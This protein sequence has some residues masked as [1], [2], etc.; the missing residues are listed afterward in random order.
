MNVD[1]ILIL[2]KK[3][4]LRKTETVWIVSLDN[5]EHPI[6]VY[7]ISVKNLNKECIFDFNNI[8][9]KLQK[10]N[11]NKFIFLHNHRTEDSLPSLIDIDTTKDLL[12]YSKK[13]N[14]ILIDHI[15]LSKDDYFSFHNHKDN[16]IIIYKRQD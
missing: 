10:D 4:R 7:D 2:F 14:I 11:S 1:E 16:K 8:K 9:D 3:K 12:K 15:I 5:D 13:K 6:A